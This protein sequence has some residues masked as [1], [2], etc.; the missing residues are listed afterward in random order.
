METP[1]FL[2][3]ALKI[4][5]FSKIATATYHIFYKKLIFRVAGPQ[6]RNRKCRQAAALY[7]LSFSELHCVGAVIY[8]PAQMRPSQWGGGGRTS[9][10]ADNLQAFF[11][12]LSHELDFGGQHFFHGH[13][14]GAA[15]VQEAF[16]Q[17]GHGV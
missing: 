5:H 13:L 6:W 15:V 14:Q 8:G 11:A 17:G 10:I 4:N 1:K 7:T 12:D 3:S 2:V 16:S 9:D